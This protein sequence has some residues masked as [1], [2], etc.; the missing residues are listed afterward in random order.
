MTE[1]HFPNRSRT[2]DRTRNRVCFLGYDRTIEV[3]FFVGIDVLRLMSAQICRNETEVLSVFDGA[4]PII[5][6]VA[7][8]VY[9]F[10]GRGHG[11]FVYNL[12]VDDF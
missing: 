1:L 12:T 9:T 11:H 4:L 8:R 5:H 7:V 2:F 6:K 3:S 10:G